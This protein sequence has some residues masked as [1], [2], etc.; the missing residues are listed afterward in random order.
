MLQALA[1][2][3][4]TT[5]TMAL[6]PGSAAIDAGDNGA[7]GTVPVNNIDQRG[8]SRPVDGNNDGNAICDVGAYEAPAD[9]AQTPTPTSTQP[10]VLVVNKLADTNDGSCD[11]ADCSL[12]EAIAAAVWDSTINFAPGLMGTIS[13]SSRLTSLYCRS[14]DPG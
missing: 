3:G 8:V 6:Q 9:L 12:R 2:N 1:N 11:A 4:G 10:I 14:G 7:C 5:L 13:L